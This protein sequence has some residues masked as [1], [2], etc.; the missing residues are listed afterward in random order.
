MLFSV[1]EET[2]KTLQSKASNHE[3]KRLAIN[4]LSKY[5]QRARGESSFKLL[6]ETSLQ[7]SRN[8]TN[9]PEIPRQ[10]KRSARVEENPSTSHQFDTAYEFYRQKYCEVSHILS[11]YSFIDS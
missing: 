11:I 3:S 2:S 4:A 10:R 5:Y 6:W 7:K 8:L 9:P 1:A